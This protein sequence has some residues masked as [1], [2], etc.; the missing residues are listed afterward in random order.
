MSG[1]KASSSPSQILSN[2]SKAAAA[3]PDKSTSTTQGQLYNSLAG[4]ISKYNTDLQA[5]P[6]VY[7]QVVRNIK[8]VDIRGQSAFAD[9]EPSDVDPET[10]TDTSADPMDWDTTP[11][12][13]Y[14]QPD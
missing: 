2:L 5:T 7:P 9:Y 3:I 1:A 6:T 10:V 13:I 4:V 11:D 12:R 8:V 14:G